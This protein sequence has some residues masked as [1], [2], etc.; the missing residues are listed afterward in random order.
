MIRDE[1][2]NEPREPFPT[3]A[4]EVPSYPYLDALI[5]QGFDRSTLDEEE[6]TIRVRCSQCAAL[7]IN[8]MACH[9]TGCPNS[10]DA[11]LD[12]DTDD[13]FDY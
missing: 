7:V 2:P 12:D 13:T 3:E 11:E 6:G 10:V 5:A 8:G 4:N 9:E 1:M